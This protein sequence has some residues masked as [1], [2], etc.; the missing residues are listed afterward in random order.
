MDWLS[1]PPLTALRAF[2]AFAEAGTMSGAGAALN[3]SHAAIS[4]QIRALEEHMGLPLLDRE[5]GRGA[6]TPAGSTLALAL[7]EGFDTIGRT[8]SALTG[9]DAER[10]LQITTTPAFASGW[11]M[12]R[13]ADFRARH[14]GVSLMLDPSPELKRIEP[15]GIDLGVRYGSGTW[16]GLEAE[17]L[18]E[19]S[20][21]IV[22]APE[23]VGQGAYDAPAQ[24]T[25]FHWLQELGTSEASDFLE[26]HGAALDRSKG[27]TSAP[28]NLMIE[29][30]RNGQGIAVVGRAFV[31][32]D[33]AAGRLRLLFED[34]R[35]KG[36]YLVTRPGVARPPVRDF[37]RWLKAQA[38]AQTRR[39]EKPAAGGG[40]LPN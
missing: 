34:R 25:A 14:P 20:I 2:A 32:A 36:Y 18:V 26:E 40:D 4:Q 7:A 22:A 6:L 29:A 19:S 11:L 23:L 1:L 15:G 30:A 35:K 39:A 31:E 17:L 37:T 10:P 38:R 24:L 33:I 16:P 9:A 5:A 3:V 28:G 13:L 27:V 8:V 21:A 12:P